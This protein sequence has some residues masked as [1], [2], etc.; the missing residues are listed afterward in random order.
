M[1]GVLE[2]N[3]GTT[4]IT[5]G[6]ENGAKVTGYTEEWVASLVVNLP[7]D[8]R[9]KVMATVQQGSITGP[10]VGAAPGAAVSVVSPV[11][12]LLKRGRG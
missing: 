7:A 1:A 12:Q 4:T 11:T 6:A 10:L 5:I 3:K 9:A 8:Q 2:V